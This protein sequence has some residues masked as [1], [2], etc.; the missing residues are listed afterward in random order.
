ML[1]IKFLGRW[2]QMWAY[3]TLLNKEIFNKED[4]SKCLS[5]HLVLHLHV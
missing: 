4:L 3:N 2:I 1:T 5:P